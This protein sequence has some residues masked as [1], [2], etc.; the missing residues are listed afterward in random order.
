MSKLKETKKSDIKL[1]YQ[2]MYDVHQIFENNGI[3]Y[4]ADAG[5]LLG[6]VRHKGIIPWDDDLDIGMIDTEYKKLKKIENVF[7]KCGYKLVKHWLGYKICYKNRKNIDDFDYSY[8]FL[9]ITSYSFDKNKIIPSRKIVR[10]TW[11][12]SYYL[13]KELYPL[14]KYKFGSFHIIGPNIHL[15]FFNRM[16]GKDWNIVAY[17]Q[18]DHKN[19]EI[20]KSIKVKLTSSMRKSSKP[21]I[22]TNKFIKKIKS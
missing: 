2:L 4:W 12:K 16:Y 13:K 11:P 8:P 15:G 5:T 18:Y 14:K 1:L 7:N 9:D 10:D 17:R 19:E 3:E 6:A 21:K 20:I 22:K